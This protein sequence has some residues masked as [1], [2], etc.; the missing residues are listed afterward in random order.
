V[1]ETE[2]VAEIVVASIKAATAPLLAQLAAQAERIA[3]LDDRNKALERTLE[4]VREMARVPGPQGEPGRPGRDGVDGAKGMDGLRGER[5]EKG[6]SGDPGERGLQGEVGPT[7]AQG[8]RG[9]D[10]ERGEKGDPGDRGRDGDL[11]PRGEKGEQG[12][13]GR[14]GQPGSQGV[15]G[16]D[17][18]R[19]EKGLDGKDGRD[20]TLEDIEIAQPNERT[21][22]FRRKDGSVLG[23]VKLYGIL[24]KDVYDP[25]KAYERG[26]AVSLG[27]SLYLAQRDTKAGEKPEDPLYARR[28]GPWR[29]AVKRGRDGRNGK[30]GL[31]GPAGPA[32][33]DRVYVPT[34]VRP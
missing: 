24:D 4:Q 1:T 6:E 22:E 21:I 28:D 23:T 13:A 19:G 31:Q 3:G 30:D 2:K 14:D 20:G 27:G 25:T 7:G 16:R 32:G 26:D 33:K 15:A 11:G 8:E 10:G 29:L 34:E 5:G 17:G 9:L 18:E 12:L